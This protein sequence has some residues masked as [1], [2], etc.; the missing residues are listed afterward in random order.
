MLCRLGLIRV[1]Y[2]L[3]RIRNGSRQYSMLARPTTTSMADLF[4]LREVLVDEDYSE[5]LPLLRQNVRLV[6][7]GANLGSFTVWLHS[8]LA[9]REAFCFE[10]E[11]DSF[12]LLRFNLAVNSCTS[13]QPL[14]CAVG[15]EERTMQLALKASSPG[16]TSLYS[17]ESSSG[18]GHAVK[19][20]AFE[21]WLSTVKGD[22][23]LLKLDCEG[24]EW[25]IL[26]RTDPAVFE[27]F[28]VVVAEVHSDPEN[29]QSPAEFRQV[30][31]GLGFRTVRSD[32]RC[33]GLYIGVRE[34]SVS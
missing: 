3:H 7:V 20:L 32:D 9:V 18:E 21:Q 17:S 28:R 25:E 31:E 15:G 16:G 6:D 34:K 30:M 24:A 19:V 14:E 27:R 23:D 26:R 33:L 13:A 2:F 4:V 5:V 8:V 22:F 12:R 29:K 11:P 10:P 1:P